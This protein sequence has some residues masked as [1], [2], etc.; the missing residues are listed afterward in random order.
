MRKSS[1]APSIEPRSDEATD[2]ETVVTDL[3]EGQYKN[4]M[5]I[6]AFDTTEG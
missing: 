1:W 5:G 2:F 3:I 6:F 4:P